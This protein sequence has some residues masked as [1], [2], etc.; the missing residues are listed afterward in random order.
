MHLPLLSAYDSLLYPLPSI[1]ILLL[2]ASSF[3]ILL[4]YILSYIALH[5]QF[6]SIQ[7]SA[8]AYIQI[9]RVDNRP[10]V[11]PS[12]TTSNTT[13]TPALFDPTDRSRDRQVNQGT[14]WLL[15]QHDSS[16]GPLAY[17][18]FNLKYIHS[19]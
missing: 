18:I 12:N 8:E 6:D 2:T 10:P 1:Y 14:Y 17:Q 3:V 13:H 16:L 4:L 5:H 7:G 15:P 11:L 19:S 9:T